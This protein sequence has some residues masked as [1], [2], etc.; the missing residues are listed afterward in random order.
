MPSFSR[1][2]SMI[3]RFLAACAISMSDLGDWCCEA[4]MGGPIVTMLVGSFCGH[5]RE[6]GHAYPLRIDGARIPAGAG[7]AKPGHVSLAPVARAAALAHSPAASLG[8]SACT[9][10]TL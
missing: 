7:T 2:I 9:R 5:A 8:P 4:G 10:R 3:G 6:R 1:A